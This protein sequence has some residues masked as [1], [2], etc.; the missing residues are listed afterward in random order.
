MTLVGKKNYRKMEKD[1]YVS[2]L[3]TD[4]ITHLD[5]DPDPYFNGGHNWYFTGGCLEVLEL[6]KTAYLFQVVGAKLNTLGKHSGWKMGGLSSKALTC[7][8]SC[9]RHLPVLGRN[10]QYGGHVQNSVCGADFSSVCQRPEDVSG[11]RSQ[12][13]AFLSNGSY[14][15]SF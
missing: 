7:I 15:G 14:E 5:N 9:Y 3:V 1:G 10:C 11:A 4:L 6:D 8:C 12:G 13:G 2:H